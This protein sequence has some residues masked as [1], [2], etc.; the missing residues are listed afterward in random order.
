MRVRKVASLRAGMTTPADGR[1]ERRMQGDV[2][3]S[4]PVSVL[5]VDDDEIVRTWIRLALADSEFEL[6]GEASTGAEALE[7]VDRRRPALILVDYRLPDGVGTELVRSLRRAGVGAQVV[8]VT[9]NAERGLNESAREAGAQAT[10]RKTG[11]RETLL[12]VLRRV[13]AGETVFDTRHPMR[14]PGAGP[15]TPREREVLR[16]AA[17][18]STNS[19]IAAELGIGRETVKTLLERAYVKLGA[20]NRTEAVSEAMRRGLL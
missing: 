11:D 1:S 8:L 15:L 18:G 12:S 2:S 13:V 5:V 19:Q 20:V 14:P 16:T 3:G 4:G 10:I 7:L 17:A 9:A 6:A